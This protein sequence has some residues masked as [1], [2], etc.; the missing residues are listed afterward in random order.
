L[1][2]ARSSPAEQADACR[3]R[4]CCIVRQRRSR[5]DSVVR[6]VDTATPP[7]V[8]TSAAPRSGS[9][10]SVRRQCR[11]CSNATLSLL[12]D[13]G[14]RSRGEAV[15]STL[16]GERNAD[17]R[18]PWGERSSRGGKRF[19]A[20]SSPM[21]HCS[22][23][24]SG[25]RFPGG[26]GEL[27]DDRCTRQRRAPAP[28]RLPLRAEHEAVGACSADGREQATASQR[29]SLLTDGGLVQEIADVDR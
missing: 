28:S 10:T 11:G 13:R 1:P 18:I 3:D 4:D 21:R 8:H 24:R 6:V 16:G 5:A 9:S 2:V 27:V 22:E 25:L 7:T 15:V 23:H 12:A 14:A 19:D 26:G 29:A 20:R 17:A